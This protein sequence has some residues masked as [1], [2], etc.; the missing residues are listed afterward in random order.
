MMFFE[1]ITLGGILIDGEAISI[2][3]DLVTL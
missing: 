1:P 3:N 2:G